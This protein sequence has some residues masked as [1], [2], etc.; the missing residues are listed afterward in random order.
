MCKRVAAFAFVIYSLPCFLLWYLCKRHMGAL[1]GVLQAAQQQVLPCV[2]LCLRY[3]ILSCEP[4]L[5][6]ARLPMC[7]QQYL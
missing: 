1:Q 2:Y 7:L 4:Q 3:G 5:C 6:M